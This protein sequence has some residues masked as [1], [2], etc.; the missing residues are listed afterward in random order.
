MTIVGRFDAEVD[1]T[2]RNLGLSTI[3]AILT[4]SRHHFSQ[5]ILQKF[6]YIIIISLFYI[7]RMS[8]V[9]RPKR[10]YWKR[11]AGHGW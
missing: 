4:M 2:K 1:T 7:V 5:Y 9:A 3:N 8:I 6:P 11:Y 10:N